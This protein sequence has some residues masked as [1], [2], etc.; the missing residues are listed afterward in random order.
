MKQR[1]LGKNAERVKRLVESQ[2]DLTVRQ[3]ANALGLTTQRVY[4][5][6]GLLRERGE[7]EIDEVAQ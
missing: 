1:P 2:P 5:L 7:L 6:L 3:I 4:Q